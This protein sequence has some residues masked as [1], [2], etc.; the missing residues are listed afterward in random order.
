MPGKIALKMCPNILNRVKMPKYIVAVT[1][2]NGKTST[3]EMINEVLKR[4]NY[5]VAYNKEG[6]N[7]I[8]GVT[9]LVLSNC[10]LF[11]RFKKDV[12]LLESD[13]RYA[14]YSFKYFSPTHYVITNLYRDQM[15]RNGNPEF[16][17][18]EI[19]KS[20]NK[21]STLVINCDD[22]IIAS[23]ENGENKVYHFGINDNKYSKIKNNF[24]YDDG[25][26]CPKCKSELVYSYYNF[27][28][29]GKYSCLKCDFKRVNPE[30][31]VSNIDLD[32][33]ILT[34]NDTNE[35]KLAFKSIYNAYNILA[36]YALTNLIG[37]E[38]SIICD[39][40]NNYLIKN[41]RV[42]QFKLGG[43][44]GTLLISKHENSVCYNQNIE[45][46]VNQKKDCTVFII[47]DAISRKYFT[48][49][50]SWLWD[51]NFD[52]LNNEFVRKIV[53]AGIYANDVA[54]RLSYTGLDFSNVYINTDI[55]KAIK[56]ARNDSIGHIY[57]LTCF[58]DEAKF[59][60][61]VEIV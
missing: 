42:K 50:T 6:S 23:L 33:G 2:S 59:T 46:I 7:Q 19:K 24:V 61:K 45:Y 51:I 12:L 11:G 25:Y 55:K 26:Y 38:P 27:G 53:I 57:V 15:T 56:Y 16:V 58:S 60:K 1:G 29:V 4:A 9:T 10:T 18:K 34:I 36:A 41:G 5:S 48:S 28:H 3:V 31:Y 30:Y 49:E 37:V 54:C 40:L 32:E 52:E 21:E 39:A 20:I 47:V 44:S 14:Q 22:P 17:L 8:D 43:N 35:I 13:E